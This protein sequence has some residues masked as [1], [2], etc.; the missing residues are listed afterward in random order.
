M[1]AFSPILIMKQT[2]LAI[3]LGT[4]VLSLGACATT[5]GQPARPLPITALEQYPL[6]AESTTRTVNLRINPNGLSD[7][8]RRAL[9]QVAAQAA[10]TSGQ[11]VNV[12]IVTSGEPSSMAA[13]NH[14]QAYL[15]THD[16]KRENL[17][18]RAVSGQPADVVSVNIV[19]FR[20][21]TYDCNE[22]WENLARTGSNQ[23]YVNFGC[24]VTSN[25]AAQVDDPRDLAHAH[26]ATATDGARKAT[27]LDHYR[28]GEVTSSASDDASKGT[29]S[30]AIN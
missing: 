12:E 30:N 23:P 7:N 9:D 18:M 28:K 16:V 13:G 26:A 4:A 1:T 14:I 15:N 11:P 3:A 2:G 27:I 19:S 25:L 5:G 21:R 8:Q 24:A 10:W 29:I 22:S 20:A 17:A 6:T